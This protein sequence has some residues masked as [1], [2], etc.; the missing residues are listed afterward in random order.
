MDRLQQITQYISKIAS[1]E[2]LKPIHLA[3]AFA[4]CNGWIVAQ[5]QQPY[6]VS[7][8]GLM[9]ASR[10]RSKATYHRVIRELQSFGYLKYNPSYHPMKASQVR[11]VTG[12]ELQIDGNR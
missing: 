7:R 2:R 6:R 1:D 3:F 10:I 8:S 9:Q 5:F 12:D 11:L 4:L